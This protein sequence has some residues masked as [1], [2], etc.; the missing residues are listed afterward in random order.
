MEQLI[1]QGYVSGRPT[2]GITGEGVSNFYQYYYHL[3]SGLFITEVDETSSAAASGIEVR[4]ILI[5]VNDNR[6][7]SMDDLNNVLYG[8]E[9]GDTVNVIIYRSGRQYSVDLVVNENTK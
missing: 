9:V 6:I 5:S 2:L 7:T 3:P 8:C 1:S 4:D